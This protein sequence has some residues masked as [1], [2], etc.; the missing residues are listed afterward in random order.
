CSATGRVLLSARPIDEVKFLLNRMA[1][2]A[3]TPRT[4]TGLR[5]I[6]NEIEQARAY[7]YAIC[8]EELELGVRSLAVPI[9]T[10]R[11]DV[12]A[13][14]SLSVSISRM[15][16]QEVIDNLLT[17]MELAKRNFAALL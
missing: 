13:A 6:L 5:D 1:R 12:I 9:R 16:R 11:G 10:G 14:L 8:D 17:E 15:S 4:R 7:G 2:P 3:L